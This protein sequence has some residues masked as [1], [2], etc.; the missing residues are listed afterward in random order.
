[1]ADKE[2]AKILIVEDD[3]NIRRF[4][5]INLERNDFKV[6]EAAYGKEAL[7]IVKEKSPALVILDVMLPDIDGFE[8]CK[9]LR[10]DDLNIAIILLTARGQDMDKVM[11]LEL[12]ADDY[13]V[14]PF[15]PMELVARIRS[16]LRRTK[17]DFHDKD[18]SVYQI[19]PFHLDTLSNRFYKH[20]K[21]IEMTPKEFHMMRIFIENPEKA[22]TRDELLNLVWGHDF[23]GDPK[24]V[25]VHVRRLREKI[26]DQPSKPKFIETVWGFGYRWRKDDSD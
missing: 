18:A 4:V 12:G 22:L 15:N 2:D 10:A 13:M 16:V 21:P 3:H 9:R 11:G 7:R 25:D 19:G 24:T 14:K 5:A 23:V 1:M 6:F 26:E 17:K 8:I 20:G